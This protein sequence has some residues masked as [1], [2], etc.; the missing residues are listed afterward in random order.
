MFSDT[1]T[2]L[3]GVI[4]GAGHFAD[5]Q[6]EAW[7][8]VEGAGIKAIYSRTRNK[9]ELLAQKYGLIVY[10]NFE[11]M[12]DEFKPGFIDIC[13]PPDS[14]LY[15]TKLSVDAGIPTLCQKPIAPTWAEC[16]ELVHY[17]E[18]RGIPLMINENWRWQGWYREIKRMI[19][20]G[21]LGEVY[22]AYFAMRPGDGW[23][24]H[25][26]PVQPYFKDME[27]FLL[28]ETGIHYIDTYR[29]LFGEISSVYC[30]TRKVNPNIAGEDMAIVHVNFANRMTGIYDANRTTYMQE[31]RS[32]AYGW[33]TI[34][35]TE[36]KLLLEQSG[37]I[38]YTRRD[39]EQKKH[40][41]E[42]PPGW[43]GGCAIATQQ[44]FIDGLLKGIPYE[45]A[46][47]EYLK[48]VQVM[49]A[50]Y[51]SAQEN[52]VVYMNKHESGGR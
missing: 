47:P 36:G 30:Q 6:L 40:E 48:S 22:H 17:A 11:A 20:Q 43:K 26:Y 52:K 3:K 23:G 13:T 44:H 50:C 7:Q 42:I 16:K 21:L 34:E 9:A 5:V 38:Y 29:Y 37:E 45:S 35:G 49:Y 19:D 39:G 8:S 46:G 14:H 25:P 31:V 24:D 15:Y 27:Q 32:P 10:D 33:M 18:A 4:I 51:E 28:Y 41:Y 12:L 1:G 2:S